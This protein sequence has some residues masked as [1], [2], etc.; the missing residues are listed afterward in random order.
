MF[1]TSD[2]GDYIGQGA[3]TLYTLPGTAIKL[4]STGS[5][6]QV[7][8]GPFGGWSANFVGGEGMT[9]LE[10][11]YYADLQRYPFNNPVKGGMNWSGNGRGCNRL[12]GWFT[13]D[14]VTYTGTTMTSIDLRF[15]QHCDGMS[16]A[17]RGKIHWV[18]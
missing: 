5:N 9:R 16:P 15:E 17:L 6:L 14:N 11:G 13:V 18:F 10:Q 3:T 12:T 4:T 7:D 8:V 1:L 2:A